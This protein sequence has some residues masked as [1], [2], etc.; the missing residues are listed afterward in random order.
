VP[1]ARQQIGQNIAA[2]FVVLDQENFHFI[3]Q[4]THRAKARVTPF[5][6]DL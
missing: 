4:S 5:K 1:A 6:K 3:L 2:I